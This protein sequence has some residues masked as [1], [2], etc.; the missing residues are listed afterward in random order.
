MP[1]D[2]RCIRV[3]QPAEHSTSAFSK[4][5]VPGLLGVREEDSPDAT[6]SPEALQ[7]ASELIRSIALAKTL[8][9]AEQFTHEFIQW[10]GQ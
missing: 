8:A 4:M 1:E 6:A 9:A 5:P 7:R 3:R 10:A 2:R